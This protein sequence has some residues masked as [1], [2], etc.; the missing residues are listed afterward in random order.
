MCLL[1]VVSNDGEDD[2]TAKRLDAMAYQ[3]DHLNKEKAEMER[4]KELELQRLRAGCDKALK[5]AKAA[6]LKAKK[7]KH[8]GV[9]GVLEEKMN[10]LAAKFNVDFDDLNSDDY[11]DP[12]KRVKDNPKSEFT[13]RGEKK[14]PVEYF[15]MA[16]NG[17]HCHRQV[18]KV[19][20]NKIAHNKFFKLIKL[21]QPW[22][23]TQKSSNGG[24]T[25]TKVTEL[26]CK[27]EIFEL[28]YLFGMYYLQCYLEKY[29][30][31]FLDYCSFLTAVSKDRT[32]SE[33]LQLDTALHGY[34]VANPE[35]NWSQDNFEVIDIKTNFL[36]EGSK[37][38][39]GKGGF[40]PRGGGKSQPRGQGSHSRGCGFF[41]RGC[42]AFSEGACCCGHS[43]LAVQVEICDRYNKGVCPGFGCYHEHVCYCGDPSHI[44]IHYPKLNPQ[45]TQGA[46]PAAN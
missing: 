41:T 20:H 14:V 28:L 37:S 33:M 24:N 22:E 3:L 35:I 2:P 8:K 10:R 19:Y 26:Q 11:P 45:P 5:S 23:M 4:K 36:H 43:R 9:S 7:H 44:A 15:G 38:T 13:I 18:D 1:L 39:W 17:I 32:V 16:L 34:Y 25:V 21:Y 40:Q 12:T 31:L 27:Y 6:K 29:A 42:G 46:A 30:T